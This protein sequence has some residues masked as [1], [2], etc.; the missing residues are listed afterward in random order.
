MG[1]G[2]GATTVGLALCIQTRGGRHPRRSGNLIYYS[3]AAVRAGRETGRVA[4]VSKPQFQVS[5]RDLVE[6]ALRT[7]DLAGGGDFVGPNRALAGTRGHQRLQRS[8]PAGYEKEVRVSHDME[9]DEFILRIQGR[10]DGLLI[11]PEETMLEE[12]KTVQG[13]WDGV[14]DALHWGQAKCYGYIHSR[15]KGLERLAIRLTYLELDTGKL[16]EFQEQF[17]FAELSAFFN[18]AVTIYLEW[19]Q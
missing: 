10:I 11:T 12:I 19:I 15:D 1:G 6:F 7:G 3:I 18:E 4:A 2:R 9:T 5:V 16:T 8:R 14:A 17:A 13:R